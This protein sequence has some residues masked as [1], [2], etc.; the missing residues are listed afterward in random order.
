MNRIRISLSSCA[1]L[2]FTVSLQAAV[3]ISSETMP[4]PGMPGFS[5]HT[6]TLVSDVPGE[7]FG[8]VD[9]GG[10]RNNNNPATGFGFFGQMN[11]VNPGGQPTI[12]S[13]NNALFPIFGR[14]A[15]QD[16]QFLVR[17]SDVVVP[18]GFAEEGPNILQAIWAWPNRV[19]PSLPLAQIVIQDGGPSITYRGIVALWTAN[20]LIEVPVGDLSELPPRLLVRANNFFI[21]N[22]D[23]TPTVFD[24]TDFGTVKPGTLQ[25]RTFTISNPGESVLTLGPPSISGPFSVVGDFPISI[26]VDSMESFTL[27][28]DTS[29][30]GQFGGVF[31]V[32]TND[33]Y[34]DVYS[35]FLAANVVPEPASAALAGLAAM[36]WLLIRRTSF[37]LQ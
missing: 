7:L 37:S 35:F 1:F 8:G 21:Q 12:F 33:P 19:G 28:L 22:G 25:Q 18:A 16:S 3:S 15:K 5:T 29:V 11:Q 10:G 30:P 13:D 6:L 23:N 2:L 27:G 17:S 4:T 34:V 9:F 14:E 24:N 32:Q 31:S 20:G 26:P 36:G